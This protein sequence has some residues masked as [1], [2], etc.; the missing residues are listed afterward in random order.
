LAIAEL[1]TPKR[2]NIH[3]GRTGGCAAAVAISHT[4]D[5]DYK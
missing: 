1:I 2:S 5:G 3:H 4:A